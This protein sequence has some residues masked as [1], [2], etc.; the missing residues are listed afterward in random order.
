MTQPDN[1]LY[2]PEWKGDDRDIWTALLNPNKDHFLS[3]REAVAI[4]AEMKALSVLNHSQP[5]T[6][7]VSPT[8]TGRYIQGAKTQ[9]GCVEA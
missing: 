2:L 5:G 4:V 9:E 6:W 7:R 3:R 8:S 1:Q